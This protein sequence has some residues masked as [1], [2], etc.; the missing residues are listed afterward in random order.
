V[1]TIL[2]AQQ[3]WMTDPALATRDA[4]AI[5]STSAFQRLMRVQPGTGEL[6]PDAATDCIF[7]SPTVYECTLPKDLKF[8]NGDELTASDVKF[9]IQRALRLNNSDTGTALLSSLDSITTDSDLVVRFQLS[10]PDSQFGYALA[11]VAASIVDE[12]VYD[13]DAALEGLPVGS[14]PYSVTSIEEE[15]VTFEIFADYKGPLTGGIAKIRLAAVADSVAAEAA[16][17]AGVADAVWRT[18]D[19]AALTRTQMA[20]AATPAPDYSYTRVPR[21][22]ARVTVLAW[23][24]DSKHRSN[25]TLRSG[26]ALALQPDR[27]LDSLVPVGVVGHAAAF[28]VGGREELPKLK[29]R[30]NLTLGYDPTAPGHAD[31]ARLLRERLEQIGSL[32]VRVV[33]QTDADLVLLDQLPWVDNAL[34]WLQR[35]LAY[36]LE[37]SADQL[38]S[39][40]VAY[41]S[42][43]TEAVAL[44]Q[45]AKLQAQAADDLSVLPVSQSDGILLLKTGV[46]LIGEPYGPGG[47]LGL[48]GFRVG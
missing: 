27:T 47:Q 5:V 18:L 46:S 13:P 42:A 29:K 21:P 12:E 14:G 31:M 48:W 40:E 20:A 30:V 1:F 26:V 22:G 7:T 24:A 8:H 11:T 17:S 3:V 9:S 37:E 25:A 2:T 15:A 4:D 43:A 33:A 35:Y 41:R 36:P 39:L 34:G 44:Q 45:L 19:D 6:K 23:N 32:S 38:A 28:P 10:Y 16:M